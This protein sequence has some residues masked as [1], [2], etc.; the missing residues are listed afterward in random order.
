MILDCGCPGEYPDWDGE[1]IDLGGWLV[2][3]QPAPMFLHMPL[4]FNLYRHRQNENILRLELKERWPGF[5]LTRS[6]AFRGSH[7]R[8]LEDEDCPAQRV[9]H[10]RSPFWVRVGVHHGD[11]GNIRPLIS[12]MQ[13]DLVQNACLPKELYLAYLTCPICAPERGGHKVMVLRRWVP[14]KKLKARLE[15]QKS[16]Q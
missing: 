15:K 13:T 5:T 6:A 11:V 4:A 10:L 16:K 7:L 12:R 9:H 8:L 2:H 3:E 1:D 14:S